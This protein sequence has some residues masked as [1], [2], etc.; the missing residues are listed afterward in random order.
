MVCSEGSISW[1]TAWQLSFAERE[2]VAEVVNK[3]NKLK[4]GE[5]VNEQL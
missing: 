5:K 2:E 4:S 3:V 1:D